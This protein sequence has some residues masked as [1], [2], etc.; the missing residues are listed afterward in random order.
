MSSNFNEH[1]T[2]KF[3]KMFLDFVKQGQIQGFRSSDK[4]LLEHLLRGKI[5][6]YGKVKLI[7]GTIL[8]NQDVLDKYEIDYE[9]L[10]SKNDEVN[11]ERPVYD[12]INIQ[13]AGDNNIIEVRLPWL[14]KDK[15]DI[16]INHF[17]Q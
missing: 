6:D 7:D 10:S 1:Y 12:R 8:K 13:I 15:F 17:I 4:I 16:L 14:P 9:S 11:E 5:T 3:A 2:V